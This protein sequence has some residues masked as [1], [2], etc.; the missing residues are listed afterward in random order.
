[1][2]PQ[3]SPHPNPS[4]QAHTRKAGTTTRKAGTTLK[5]TPRLEHEPLCRHYC[6]DPIAARQPTHRKASTHPLHKPCNEDR[7]PQPM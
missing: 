5:E 1:H 2:H 6:G 7:Q 4:R 3:G